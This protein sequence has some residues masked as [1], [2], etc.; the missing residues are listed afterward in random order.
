M[1]IGPLRTNSEDVILSAKRRSGANVKQLRHDKR[2]RWLA[3]VV[4]ALQFAL[5]FG[6]VHNH[7]LTHPPAVSLVHCDQ[8][9]TSACPLH[10]DDDESHCS[11]CMTMAIAASLILIT[12]P[13]IVVPR[14]RLRRIEPQGQPTSLYYA[15][16]VP[17]RQGSASQQVAG[18]AAL[19]LMSA[20]NTL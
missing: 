3:L 15:I 14:F 5:S 12:L 13:A 17:F 11:I 16:A 18:S 20:H 4:L 2:V 6:H 10:D 19:I 8:S 1:A 9:P 7:S